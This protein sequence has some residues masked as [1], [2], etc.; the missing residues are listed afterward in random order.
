MSTS[1]PA[2]SQCVQVDKMSSAPGR[3]LRSD[4]MQFDDKSPL[5]KSRCTRPAITTDMS[6]LLTAEVICLCNMGMCSI[7]YMA[8]RN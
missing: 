4:R 8:G 7:E 3:F 5:G 6:A 2:V 1:S